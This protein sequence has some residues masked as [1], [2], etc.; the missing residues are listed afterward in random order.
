MKRT[1]LFISLAILVLT[2]RSSAAD[3]AAQWKVQVTGI[4]VVAPAPEGKDRLRA[5]NDS[6]G[7]TVALMVT[8][9]SG[10]IVNVNTDDSKLEV[11]TDDKGTNL[12]AAKSQNHFSES[13][14]TVWSSFSDKE[15]ASSKL[16]EVHAS[17]QP[18]KGATLFNISGKLVVQTASQTKQFTADNVELKLGTKLSLG[19]TPMTVSSIRS[20][21]EGQEVSLNA[22]QDLSHILKVEFF[23]A[24]GNKIEARENG[25]TSWSGG[26]TKDVTLEYRLKKS[27]DKIKIVATCW[28]DLKTTEVPITIK[29]GVGL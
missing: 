17:G 22:K 29:T 19:N 23:D 6:P 28:T 15:E 10:N 13:G 18:A 12:L 21:M 16:V 27:V 11:F 7:A 14:F 20:D 25:T 3:D 8:A 4:R 1:S 9:P 5:F 2:N 24:Q 26:S